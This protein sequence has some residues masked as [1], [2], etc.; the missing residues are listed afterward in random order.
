VIAKAA[1]VAV[2]STEYRLAPENPFPA[3]DEDVHDVAEYLVDSAPRLYGG[4]LK[5]IGG[6]SAGATLSMSTILHLLETRPNFQLAGAAMMYGL[7][8]WSLSPSVRTFTTPLI[9]TTEHVE[10][11]GDAYLGKMS[12]QER[13]D[14]AISP[15]YHP[16]FKYPGSTLATGAISGNVKLPPALFLSGTRD[17]ILDDTVLMSFRYQVA[18]GEA[19]VKFVEGAPHAF[20]LFPADRFE[21]VARGRAILTEFLQEKMHEQ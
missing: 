4:P 8:D 20:L 17:A 12:L 7:Y 14:P 16:I 11:Y 18:G 5:F 10:H 2:I 1:N 19:H 9:M 3:G 21:M 6:E 13:R 15:I